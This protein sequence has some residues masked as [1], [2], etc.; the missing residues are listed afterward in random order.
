[1]TRHANFPKARRTKVKKVAATAAVAVPAAM[2]A[3]F[4]SAEAAG[5][6]TPTSSYVV[7]P[8]DTLSAIAAAHGTSWSALAEANHLANPNLI[9]PG[10]VLV[11]GSSTSSEYAPSYHSVSYSAPAESTYSAPVQHTTY[12]APAESTYS[13]PVQHTTYSAPVQHTSYSAPSVHTVSASPVSSSSSSVTPSSSFQSCVISRE[14]G[15][16]ASAT[17]SSGHY[18]LYQ[19]SA[20]TWAAYGGSPST[21]GHASAAQQ[22]AVF[23]N[24]MAQGGAS[25][26]APYDGC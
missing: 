19:F 17:N 5:A 21:F 2:G 23:N 16:N 20:S 6:S 13:A 11:L 4:L 9:F 8:G 7:Q 25:N 26:W 3:M 24:A 10:Q 18:G 22:T 14:S 1:L 12:S 15:G